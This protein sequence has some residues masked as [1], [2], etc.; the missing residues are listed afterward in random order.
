[1]AKAAVDV[2]N[3]NEESQNALKSLGSNLEPLRNNW[4]G[5][6]S[7]AFATLMDRYYADSAKLHDALAAISQ[8]LK[9][10]NVAYTRQEE[11]ASQSMSTI[12]NVLG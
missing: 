5:T 1:M 6:A 10:S 4:K 7:M 2:D 12:T 8:Q 9:D 11:E 3:V